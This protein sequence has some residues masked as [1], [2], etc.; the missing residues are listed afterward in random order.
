MYCRKCGK[1]INYDAEIC[2]E[3]QQNEELFNKA[4]EAPVAQPVQPVCEAVP[5]KKGS[6]MKGFGLA[7]ASVIVS[8][9]GLA[10]FYGIIIGFA[11]VLE[12]FDEA[13]MYLEI[14]PSVYF[15][16]IIGLAMTIFSLVGGIISMT[17]FFKAKKNG[18]TKPIPAL[19]MG[20]V[21][22]VEAAASLLLALCILMILLMV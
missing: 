14:G 9:F 4:E 15:L 5:E 13:T 17:V 21:S 20:I 12:D 2:V 1:E 10:F 3:C 16:Y 8:I 18:E 22:V 7:L 19:I 6:V 11:E